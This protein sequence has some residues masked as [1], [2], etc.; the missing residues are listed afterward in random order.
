MSKKK[1]LL[2]IIQ[3]LIKKEKD[4]LKKLMNLE[5]LISIMNSLLRNKKNKWDHKL[6]NKMKRNNNYKIWINSMKIQLKKHKDNE[7]FISSKI[8][9]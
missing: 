8:W 6:N 4:W 3:N 7:L 1:K 5:K 2:K 9:L